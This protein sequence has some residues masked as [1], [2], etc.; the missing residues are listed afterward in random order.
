MLRFLLPEKPKR[1]KASL[2]EKV[3]SA[4]DESDVQGT[5]FGCRP[6]LGLLKITEGGLPATNEGGMLN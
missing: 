5:P 6:F 3:K 1:Y 4:F 2:E